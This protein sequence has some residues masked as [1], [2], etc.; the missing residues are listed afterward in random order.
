MRSRRTVL[1]ATLGLAATLL[2]PGEG[3][4]GPLVDHLL[5]RQPDCPPS[6]Y[7]PCHYWTPEVYRLRCFCHN[8]HPCLWQFPPGPS[9]SVPPSF[10]ITQFPSPAVNPRD[11]PYAPG[12]AGT[13]APKQEP[14]R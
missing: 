5:G 3:T 1:F 6:M 13:A 4:A 12:P 7:S 14:K 10:R 9:P 8:D 11:V 2:S